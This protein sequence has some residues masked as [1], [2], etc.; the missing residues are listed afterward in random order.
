MISR[1]DVA[2]ANAMARQLHVFK[3]GI[4]FVPGARL[5]VLESR[6]NNWYQC[7]IVEVDWGELDI[8]VH[9]ERW[10]NRFD[11]WLKM[12]STRIRPL[13][14]SSQRKDKKNCQF[15]V[16]DRVTA[17][18]AADGK[19]YQA[20]VVKVL[21][22]DQYEVLFFDGV[23]KVVRSGA[24][25]KFEPKG[26]N[27][28]GEDMEPGSSSCSPGKQLGPHDEVVMLLSP[29]ATT[30]SSS[31][32]R[33]SSPEPDQHSTDSIKEEELPDL[34][35]TPIKKSIFD[36]E[37]IDQ[38]RKPKRKAAVEELFQS[39]KKKRKHEF[40]GRKEDTPTSPKYSKTSHVTASSPR[41]QHPANSAQAKRTPS[42]RKRSRDTAFGTEEEGP[43]LKQTD[44]SLSSET[45][46][47]ATCDISELSLSSNL[48][49]VK[50]DNGWKKCCTRRTHG[51]TAGKWDMYYMAPEGKKIR[52]KTDL[53]RY[54]EETGHSVDADKFDF[55]VKNMKDVIEA[56]LQ[57]KDPKEVAKTRHTPK[58]QREPIKDVGVVEI[59]EEN[60]DE[61]EKAAVFDQSESNKNLVAKKPEVSSVKKTEIVPA[62]AK[63]PEVV[64]A[65]K[66][67]V[68][69]LKKP[70][71]S[72]AKKPEVSSAK[73][74]EVSSAKKIEVSSAKKTEVSSAKKTEVS[75]AKKTEVSSAKKTEVSSAKKTEVLSTK[76][77]EISSAKKTEA[78]AKKPDVSAKKPE[79]SS[80]KKTDVCSAKKTEVSSTKKNEVKKPEAKRPDT[81]LSESPR[82]KIEI[83]ILSKTENIGM[84]SSSVLS[85][86][87]SP[88]SPTMP[89]ALPRSL[90]ASATVH[91][92]GEAKKDESPSAEADTAPVP[93]PAAESSK[94]EATPPAQQKHT[95]KKDPVRDKPGYVAPNEFVVRAE[96]NEHQC[97]KEGCG[98]GF[99]KE[100]LLQMHIKHYHPE[101][102][103]KSSSWAPNVA[104]L[105][106]ARTVGD[107]LETNASPTPASPPIDKVLK[108]DILS[109]K[110]S[111]GLVS[112]SSSESRGKTGEKKHQ[113]P[114]K[115][116]S[117][118]K[119]TKK[120][121][122]SKV[123]FEM[124]KTTSDDELDVKEEIDEYIDDL[125]EDTAGPQDAA[126]TEDPDYIPCDGDLS[127]KKKEKKEK[128][129]TRGG[130]AKGKKRKLV[131]SESMS[132]D[133]L[134]ETK[135]VTKYRYSTRKGSASSRINVSA[136]NDSFTSEANVST[137]PGKKVQ[138]PEESSALEVEEDTT[139]TWAEGAE[140]ASVQETSAEIIN[141]GCGSTEEEGLMLQ[142]DVC[143][144]WQHGACYNIVGEDQVP[145]KYICSLCDHPKLERSSHK[146]RHHQD[147]LKEGR[148]PRFSFS[149][150]RGDV[151]LE[152]CIR[153]GHELTANV[154]QLSEVLHSL[155]LKLHIAKEADHPKF[156][157]W[158]KKWD[159]KEENSD[160][161]K[162]SSEI[163]QADAVAPLQ[164]LMNIVEHD[165]SDLT[166]PLTNPLI[167]DPSLMTEG[168]DN[169]SAPD[170]ASA[171]SPLEQSINASPSEVWD[172]TEQIIN[173][174]QF[175]AQTDN[176]KSDSA[177]LLQNDSADAYLQQI[178]EEKN[179]V[180][181]VKE[182]KSSCE[183][184]LLP[185]MSDIQKHAT[186]DHTLSEE[187]PLSSKTDI[188]SGTNDA[189]QSCSATKHQVLSKV[190]SD[191]SDKE[192]IIQTETNIKL[193]KENSKISDFQAESLDA[194]TT[195]VEAE[196]LTENKTTLQTNL[197]LAELE[198]ENDTDSKSTR[199][200]DDLEGDTKTEDTKSTD[201]HTIVDIAKAPL[202]EGQCAGE[203]EEID[204]KPALLE[205][206]ELEK[207]YP[208]NISVDDSAHPEGCACEEVKSNIKVDCKE[209]TVR[210]K[211]PDDSNLS[212][213]DKA[214]VNIGSE[215]DEIET[216]QKEG[217]LA[218]N[219]CG[220]KEEIKTA[221]NEK[222]NEANT[223][224]EKNE[225]CTERSE[226]D[227]N[228]SGTEIKSSSTEKETEEDVHVVIKSETTNENNLLKN[229]VN[230]DDSGEKE[231]KNY[232]EV[233]SDSPK[234]LCK[235]DENKDCKNAENESINEANT[236]CIKE[237]EEEENTER[238]EQTQ[239]KMLEV[240]E[241]DN[242]KQ[243]D[244]PSKDLEGMELPQ[245][246]VMSTSDMP[247][248]V[249]VEGNEDT[250]DDDDTQ[251]DDDGDLA[252]DLGGLGAAGEGSMPG[253]N[254]LAALLSSQT[255]LE[256]LVTQASSALAPHV[257]T[258]SVS[259]PIIP[260]AERIEPVNC[261]LNLLEHVQIVQTNIT[262][263]F[264][265]IEKQLEVLEAEM[266]L[267]ADTVDDDCEEDG[268]ERDPATLQAR[269][270]I[271]LILNDV[272]VVKKIAEFTH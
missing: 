204:L 200:S 31:D 238:K 62:P 122:S 254:D 191:S 265:Q 50:L 64:P 69:S 269:A 135:A 52:C 30:A 207:N 181:D 92:V 202:N 40:H 118:S 97:P 151:R 115:G 163:A 210:E 257:P 148:L 247:Q 150:T 104:D 71:V 143:L 270:L 234:Y 99:R 255:E 107:H 27:E 248:C 88:W 226:M 9:Y 119:E 161:T 236:T 131:P 73:K 38:K 221:K 165:A 185:E 217:I 222:N 159:E 240:Q 100:N 17:R 252:L 127:Q 262:K 32:S 196:D 82:L 246:A 263:R 198:H 35:T 184:T 49:T 85:T 239:E 95:I 186:P 171:S 170:S 79:V 83:P 201:E 8:L 267:C 112:G 256:H 264:D 78:P 12:D 205:H 164:K 89:S 155:R 80:A 206:V 235:S 48:V 22:D 195:D 208:I 16:G 227:T 96:H 2:Q 110:L 266:G 5:E 133:D 24:L 124:A 47:A 132:E 45:P 70:E 153:R 166:P 25:T 258:Q 172:V 136:I 76:K 90:P 60:N 37:I 180:D 20:R 114:S 189:Q 253:G 28:T 213:T 4:D 61:E 268:E 147:W 134:Q 120:K 67:E 18:W 244:N 75:S 26:T 11:E 130:E 19:R 182:N 193:M 245:P 214:K 111:R 223:L 167:T 109:K 183:I 42:S 233:K 6:D 44:F 162:V 108:Q 225:K 260:E 192:S 212:L 68:P 23:T 21:G 55:S 129:K 29:A 232:L 106:Y 272:N 219:Q 126:S 87:A 121:D 94:P 156:V 177:N 251:L 203:P 101:I 190:L 128:R 57:E 98:K 1:A 54:S 117:T 173:G 51:T 149:R 157:M 224:E 179:V 250:M 194:S 229:T 209:V 39:L 66:T 175:S 86:S 91:S 242:T 10:S 14:R 231:D 56:H 174:E 3:P 81:K 125:E 33:S 137:S 237:E 103:K 142:C 41:L 228:S 145:D 199:K 13:V 65:K 216:T 102:L 113:G 72:S 158:H 220:S 187:A 84:L 197:K 53:L 178:K 218:T 74:P 7:K 243:K 230:E 139:D 215:G 169:S 152:A 241:L 168:I 93:E 77:T 211:D 46:D 160:Q 176:H 140:N 36:V 144:C 116:V 138:C 58:D 259:V 43:L 249:D 59:K 141:C 63:K 154:L 271:K 261:K 15:R 105:A 34:E 146:F 188:V 123:E